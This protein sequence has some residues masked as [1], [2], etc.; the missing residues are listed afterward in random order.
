[1][2]A[3]DLNERLLP[4]EAPADGEPSV[5]LW[6]SDVVAQALR[7]LEIPFIALNPG[8]SFRGLHDSLVNYLGNQR[9]QML[10]CLHEEHA[11][12]IAHG[13]AK[14]TDTPMAVALHSNLGL[15]HATMAIFNAY[16]D[17]MPILML[18]ATGP[19]DA[20][21][22]RAW[23][24]WLHT[25]T[26][27]AALIR[28]F[29]KWDDQP[30]SPEAAV[31]AV[32]QAHRSASA[33][34]KS[35][36]YVCLDA[37]LQELALAKATRA[38]RATRYRPARSPSPSPDDIAALAQHL[39]RAKNPILLY[40][41]FTRSAHGWQQRIAL[42][43]RLDAQ[44][45]T[46]LKLPAAFPTRHPLHRDPPHEFTSPV[47]RQSLKDAD[48]IVAFDWLDLGGTLSTTGEVNGHVVS[49]SLDDQLHT[50][51]GKES[52]APV[53]TDLQLAADTDVSVDALLACL[54]AVGTDGDQHRARTPSDSTPQ[55]RT[56][57]PTAEE[58]NVSDIASSLRDALGERTSTIIRFPNEWTG[59]LWDV[60]DP[61]DHLGG[62][63]GEGVG[64]GPG[65]AVGAALA[66][67][68]SGR[69]PIAILGDGDYL[70]GINALW[71][72]AHY[73][74]PLLIV[75]ANNRSYFNDEIHQHGVALHRERP[76]TNRWIGQHITGPD[77][78][79]VG[80]AQS[81]GLTAEGPV[82]SAEELDQSLRRA[83]A[84]VE[85]GGTMV[86]DVRIASSVDHMA[87][88]A[89]PSGH[90]R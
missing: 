35:P 56:P 31:E 67:R 47:L 14:V 82:S 60:T 78:D 73:Q 44:V 32:Y 70:M 39:A 18:G 1:M 8:S 74:L 2:Q 75:V 90:V 27:Q 51:W 17:R 87:A 53:P 48:V 89:A 29:A 12:A 86:V 28:P 59:D 58:L 45:F 13:Y 22:R 65:M 83:I 72:A 55:V 41:R 37:S 80:L 69:I 50:G 24:D 42:A 54:C 66:L 63:G 9:P 36:T 23:I 26:D 5:A 25:T 10:L 88:N 11:V 85:A 52:L 38:V 81:Q 15:M 77:L 20:A 76:T 49:I 16:C 33:T 71:T 64:S 68:G 30:L 3:T 40:G 7:D 61:L 43:E 21:R 84:A 46:H 4:G 79:L 62:D 57:A 34:P 6:G 19:L